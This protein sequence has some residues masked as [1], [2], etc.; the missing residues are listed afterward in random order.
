MRAAI[1]IGTAFLLA[2]LSGCGE[3]LYVGSNVIWT[4]LH[5]D[6]T[7]SEWSTNMGGGATAMQ[8]TT[9]MA[10]NLRA[11][12]GKWSAKLSIMTPMD[13]TQYADAS[14]A[15][16]I[17]LPT[18]GYFSAWYYLPQT[19]NVG[20]YWVIMKIRER[21]IEN[22][23]T[24]AQ[25]LYDLNL[26]TTS[27]GGMSLRLYDHR[28]NGDL[29]LQMMDPT[30]PVGSWFQIE[31]YYHNAQD[32][33]GRFTLWLDGAQVLDVS[34]KSMGLSPWVGWEAS[35]IGD[36]LTPSMADLFI[37]DAAVSLTRVGPAG[38]IAR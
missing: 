14:L 24:T 3:D 15:R 12:H 8:N 19:V 29:M 22:D 35:S 16:R 2:T 34:G 36:A 7:L 5:E 27:N 33:T 1:G 25:E 20:V 26:K 6:G 4:A 28:T 23:P 37:D 11:H 31:A 9:I 10:S 18:E 30:V 21:R 13:P 38:V 32:T 17:G